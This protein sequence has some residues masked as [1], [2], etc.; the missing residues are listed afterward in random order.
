MH[1]PKS[2]PHGM[3]LAPRAQP[4]P[5]SALAPVSAQN[6]PLKRKTQTKRHNRFSQTSSAGVKLLGWEF[7]H[8]FPTLGIPASHRQLNQLIRATDQDG[9][10][11]NPGVF[12]RKMPGV[13]KRGNWEK[14]WQVR[15]QMLIPIIVVSASW[16]RDAQGAG[17]QP[18]VLC[19]AG[20]GPT[21]T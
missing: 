19:G 16:A 9:D 17:D 10:V 2:H 1:P 15:S 13:W 3:L 11:Q 14:F 8:P 7:Q 12:T 4:G 18:T 6:S 20:D 5:G 21:A